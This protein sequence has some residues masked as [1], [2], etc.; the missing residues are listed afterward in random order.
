MRL[1]RIKPLDQRRFKPDVKA[2]EIVFDLGQLACAD[3]LCR[4][5]PLWS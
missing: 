2:G 4:L 1:D 3:N 5:R